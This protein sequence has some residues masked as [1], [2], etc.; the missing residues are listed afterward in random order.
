MLLAITFVTSFEF[1]SWTIPSP[2]LGV[3]RLVS[4]PYLN[5]VLA[6]DRHCM[7]QEGFPEFGKF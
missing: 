4:T 1:V 6:R 5:E 7:T 2:V 3:C